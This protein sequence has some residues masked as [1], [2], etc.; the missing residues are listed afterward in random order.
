MRS[1]P[2]ALVELCRDHNFLAY[3][4][5]TKQGIIYDG[6]PL[7]ATPRLRCPVSANEVMTMFE[8]AWIVK[9]DS[10]DGEHYYRITEAGRKACEHIE[11]PDD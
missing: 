4:L 2:P 6:N 1:L 10:R 7:W 5:H 11:S 9:F 3:N 8:N